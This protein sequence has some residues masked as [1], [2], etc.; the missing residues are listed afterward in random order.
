M[1]SPAELGRRILHFLTR[2]KAERELAEEMRLHRELLAERRRES[3]DSDEDAHRGARRRFGNETRLREESRD[4]WGWGW[5]DSILG[6]LR[7]GFRQLAANPGFTLTA[8][9]TLALGIGANTAIFTVLNAVLIRSLPVEDP[10]RLVQI[11]PGE[12]AFSSTNP[13]WEA[14]RDTQQAFPGALAFSTEHFDLNAGGESDFAQGLWVSGDFFRTLGVEPLVGRVIRPEDDVRGGAPIAVLSHGFWMERFAGDPDVVGKTVR[15]ENRPFEIVGV[16]PAWFKG[17]DV[18]NRFD[19]ALPIGCEPLMRVDGSALDNRSWWWLRMV[20]RMPDGMTLEEARAYAESISAPV[21]EATTPPKWDA[22]GQR[23]YRERTLLVD[24]A[25]TGFSFFGRR[26]RTALLTLLAV[27]GAILLITCANIANLMLARAAAR[28]REVAIRLSI[29]AGR[30]RVVRQMLTESLLIAALGAG[31][32]FFLARWGASGLVGLLSGADAYQIDLTPDLRVLVFTAGVALATGLLFGLAPALRASGVQPNVFLKESSQ[33]LSSGAKLRLGRALVV[34]QVALSLTLLV[35]AGVFLQTLR[36]L[37]GVL[38]QY[39]PEGVSVVVAV[40]PDQTPRAERTA[41]FQQLLDR[42]RAIPG[43]EAVGSA[44]IVPVSGAGWNDTLVRHGVDAAD[45]EPTSWL[46][47]VSDGY[48]ETLGAPLLGGRDFNDRDTLEAPP[49]II[50]GETAARQLFGEQSA[51]GRLVAMPHSPD[52]GPKVFEVVGVVRDRPYQSL[53]ED[54]RRTAFLPMAQADQPRERIAF[55]VRS[56]GSTTA[57]TP[58]LR[59]AFAEVDPGISIQ[60]DSFE[61]QLIGSLSQQRMMALLSA[62]FGMLAV[63]IAMVGLYGLVAYR[64]RG[65]EA[66]IG[67]RLALGAGRDSIVWLILRDVLGLLGA[68]V[69]VGLGASLA[70]GRLIESQLYGVEPTNPWVLALA[71]VALAVAGVVAGF[72]PARRASRLDPLAA[73]RSE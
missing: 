35:G 50:L 51:I 68:G 71:A 45:D 61:T 47:R 8:L 1:M 72:L 42:L 46:N 52:D 20:A 63:L 40:A 2:G 67:V 60:I 65:R 27:V 24:P 34:T 14:F 57:L 37:T 23:S 5:L 33:T 36:N 3:G 15:L 66:E 9:L 54:P 4:A 31:A 30:W 49:V 13:I 32:G 16:T 69:A 48:F 7:Y 43:V 56:A 6:D 53:G 29:G 44:D 38:D 21:F 41:L 18:D 28:S 62:F 10:G 17:L 12:R 73:L 26:Y 70:A 25:A 22:E 19:V 39:R 55:L 59:D 58:S 64:S 11:Q